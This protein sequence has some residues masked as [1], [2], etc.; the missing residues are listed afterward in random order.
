MM[1]IVGKNAQNGKLITY[2]KL[3]VVK[4][5]KVLIHFLELMILRINGFLKNIQKDRDY[6]DKM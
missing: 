3:N 1:E 2:T 4:K 6:V 5:M